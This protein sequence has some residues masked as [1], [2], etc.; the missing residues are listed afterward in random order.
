MKMLR[1]PQSFYRF[2]DTVGRVLCA[3]NRA[4]ALTEALISVA[5]GTIVALACAALLRLSDVGLTQLMKGIFSPDAPPPVQDARTFL[6][7]VVF[8]ALIWAAGACRR[9]REWFQHASARGAL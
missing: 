8:G 9:T 4:L 5:A 1:I 7:V 3:I 2:T 6:V